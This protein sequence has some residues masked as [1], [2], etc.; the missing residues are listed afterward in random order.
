MGQRIDM[1]GW[2][3]K[4]HGVPDSRL[5][6]IREVPNY[7]TEHHLSAS[8]PYWEC[9]CECGQTIIARGTGIRYGEV[10]SCGCLRLERLRAKPPST[11]SDYVGQTFGLLTV[12]EKTD[13]RQNGNIIYKCQC[14]CGNIIET[15]QWHLKSGGSRSCGC[16]KSFGERTIGQILQ[17]KGISYKKEYWF[18]ELKDQKPLPFD[19]AIFD[20]EQHLL[21]LI[22]CQG[23]Q[24][25][26]PRS[27]FYS[28]ILI[29][30]DQQKREYCQANNIPL[31][32]L[33]YSQGK[34]DI[35]QLMNFL[36]K[37]QNK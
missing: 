28:E 29:R 18:E 37:I 11:S 24:H 20:P 3:M 27:R 6:V 12:I 5:T 26:N 25:Y 1:T 8:R 14:E 10:L 22:E 19:F 32:E 9:R 30:H 15:T 31:L 17:Q 4:E 16:I 2:V 33:D 34:I 35:Q 7:A 23:E 36:E 21:G 13:K